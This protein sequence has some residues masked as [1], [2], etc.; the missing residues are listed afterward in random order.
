[1]AHFGMLPEH[2]QMSKKNRLC[3][4]EGMNPNC[5][6][7]T[8]SAKLYHIRKYPSTPYHYMK[9]TCLSKCGP[10]VFQLFCRVL[11]ASGQNHF[12]NKI[13]LEGVTWYVG[14]STVLKYDGE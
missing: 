14:L 11:S 5:V 8:L 3:L 6:T 2:K 10:Q 4:L 9:R 7:E 1:M 12:R 13:Q